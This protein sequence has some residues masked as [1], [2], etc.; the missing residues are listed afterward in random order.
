[1]GFGERD[2]LSAGTAQLASID[3]QLPIDGLVM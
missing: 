2:P 1:V 3:F